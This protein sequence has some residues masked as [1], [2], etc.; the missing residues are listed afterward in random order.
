METQQ[1]KTSYCIGLETGKNLI[2]QFADMDLSLLIQGFTDG[3]HLY[4][5]KITSEEIKSILGSLQKHVQDQQRQFL[6][7]VAEENKKQSES[8]LTHNKQKENIVA[9]PSGLQYE[10]LSTGS[11]P[12]PQLLDTVTVHYQGSFL[13]GKIFDSSYTRGKPQSLAINRTIPGWAEALQMMPVGSKWRLFVP[14]YLAYGEM[15]R[16]G[17][18]P[19]NAILVF[20]V[21][22]LGINN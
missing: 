22:L 17:Q 21:E 7:K 18:I 10:V 19:P 3:I 12:K 6:I 14:P 9:C 2:A 13:D 8:F 5:P 4:P 11:G 20:E 15:G 16:P 1:E